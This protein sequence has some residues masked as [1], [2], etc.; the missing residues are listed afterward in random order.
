M[1]INGIIFDFNGTLFFD[2]PY[3]V[4]AWDAI[5]MEIAN[6]HVTRE[7]M[8]TEYSGMPNVDTIR[9]M[10]KGTFTDEQCEF[11]SQK[12]EEMYRKAVA[13]TPGGAHLAP[14]AAEFFDSLKAKNIPF[15][16]ASSSII[17]N[18]N[19]FVKTFELDRWI[20]PDVIIYDDG[21]Y[22]NKIQMFKDAAERIGVKDHILIFEDSLSG[23]KAGDAVGAD[24]IVLHSE[25]LQKYYK[26]FPS[27]K[28]VIQ[29]YTDIEQVLASIE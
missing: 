11:Y 15:T 6:E 23:I 12:K 16:I 3:H 22:A 28:A 8:E 5:G 26:D 29:D 1:K 21:S 13:N 17:E 14:G 18:I 19:F 9:K 4:E 7:R 27:I 10:T 20:N 24:L 25:Q 2:T